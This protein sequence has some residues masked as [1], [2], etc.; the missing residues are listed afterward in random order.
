MVENAVK[1]GVCKVAVGG[2]VTL[3]T[4]E[5]PDCFE[6]EISDN[7]AGFDVDEAKL[8]GTHV[9]I[10]NSRERVRMMCGGKLEVT[11]KVGEG[12]RITISLPKAQQ[13]K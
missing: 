1:H 7:G 9:G 11:S 8:G 13:K 2:T 10:I 6:V 12:T 5:M 3:S 4:R